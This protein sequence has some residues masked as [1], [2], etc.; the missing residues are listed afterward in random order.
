[1]KKLTTSFLTLISILLLTALNLNAQ[2]CNFPGG[3]ITASE[4]TIC[5]GESTTITL[6]NSVTGTDYILVNSSNTEIDTVPGNGASVD[7]ATISLNSTETF[8]VK[9]YPIDDALDFDGVDDYVDAGSGINLANNSFTIEAWVKRGSNDTRDYLFGHGTNAFTNNYLHIGWKT[10]TMVFA[11]YG[12]DLNGITNDTSLNWHHWAFTYDA[13]TND[14]KMYKDGVLVASDVAS[15]DYQGAGNF[16]IGNTLIGHPH[17]GIIDDVRVW[18]HARTVAEINTDMD[19][20]LTG[21]EPG[22]LVFYDFSEGT[23]SSTSTDKTGNGNDGTLTN[24]DPNTDWVNGV[25]DCEYCYAD[26][27]V[28]ITVN[29]VDTS[30]TQSGLTLTANAAGATFQWI[31]C[32]NNNSVIAGETGQSFTATANGNYAVELTENGCVD[33]S[34]CV[35]IANVGIIESSFGNALLIY[36]NPTSGNFSIDLGARYKSSIVSITD[37][38]GRL[39][40]SRTINQ[41]EILKLSIEGPRGIYIVSVQAGDNKAIIRL[42]KE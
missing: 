36:P 42:V 10:T 41:S 24:M 15:A 3:T 4:D 13:G 34:T 14:R 32:D 9:A 31:D 30:V 38:S 39:I 2:N 37:I 16:L 40:D 25:I 6:Y 35:N 21:T 33:T 11:F 28:V 26:S 19:S 23:G 22:L 5:A 18:D 1:M 12:N 29:T 17:D 7:F 20:C 27:A 8:S